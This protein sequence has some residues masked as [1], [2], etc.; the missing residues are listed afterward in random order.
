MLRIL[1]LDPHWQ[2]MDGLVWAVLLVCVAVPVGGVVYLVNRHVARQW[3]RRWNGA[4]ARP[5]AS[6]RLLRMTI[7]AFL[8]VT[9]LVVGALLW[10]A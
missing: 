3:D 4:P 10:A 5:S 6:E 7:L 8:V 9:A 2:G 1:L